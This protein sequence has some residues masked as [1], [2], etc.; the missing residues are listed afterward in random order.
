MAE[1]G[2]EPSQVVGG[3]HIL[4]CMQVY[5]QG[6]SRERRSLN[7]CLSGNPHVQCGEGIGGK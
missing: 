6:L 7:Q 3:A 5:W 1:Y 4:S 2:V